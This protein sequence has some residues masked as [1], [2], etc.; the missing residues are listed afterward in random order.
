[1]EFVISSVFV[2]HA[3][4]PSRLDNRQDWADYITDIDRE[5]AALNE[6]WQAYCDTH[7][8]TGADKVRYERALDNLGGLKAEAIS[9]WRTRHGGRPRIAS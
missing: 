8:P 5:E 4:L 9:A 1:M 3:G 2:S 7:Q 6:A